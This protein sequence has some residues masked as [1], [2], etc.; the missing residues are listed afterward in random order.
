M[1]TIDSPLGALRLCARAGELV[2][3]YLPEQAAPP[4]SAP[5]PADRGVLACAA[6]QLAEYFAG[7][8]RTFDLPLAPRG[9]GFQRLVWRALL[10]IPFGETRSYG[11][12]ARAIGRGAASRAV[13]AANAK[14]PLSIVV[15]C[16]R[17]VA[18]S[19]DLTG[20]AGGLYAKRWLLDHEHAVIRPPE[21]RRPTPDAQSTDARP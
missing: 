4:E 6:A 9:T 11:E 7:D 17:V 16:H 2:G 20:Y 3:I 15:P 14:N 10:A 21:A 19:G 13:G 5:V 12:I 18:T 1:I 8:R